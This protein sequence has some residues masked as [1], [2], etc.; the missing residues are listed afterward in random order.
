[1]KFLRARG[2][3]VESNDKRT[4]EKYGYYSVINGYKEPF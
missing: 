1:M 2:L 4:L 3:A